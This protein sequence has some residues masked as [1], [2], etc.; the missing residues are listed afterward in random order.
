MDNVMKFKILTMYDHGKRS[1]SEIAKISGAKFSEV[2]KI[3]EEERETMAISSEKRKEV[4]RLLDEGMTIRRI[5]EETGVSH[6]TISRIK[7][8]LNAAINIPETAADVEVPV[9]TVESFGQEEHAEEIA[10]EPQKPE[11]KPE[12]VI[13]AEEAD[14]VEYTRLIPPQTGP[15]EEEPEEEEAVELIESNPVIDDCLAGI[16]NKKAEKTSSH[17]NRLI[18]KIWKDLRKLDSIESAFAADGKFDDAHGIR[19]RIDTVVSTLY[20]L[21]ERT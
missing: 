7:A 10:E 19:E 17:I 8:E 6:G 3:I 15:E 9:E 21:C 4:I 2:R 20:E 11:P 1:Y 5:E 12:P 18:S 13:Q 14:G 16:L